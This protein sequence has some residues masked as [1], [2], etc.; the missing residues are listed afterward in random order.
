[1]VPAWAAMIGPVVWLPGSVGNL[2]EWPPSCRTAI[3]ARFARCSLQHLSSYP[4]TWTKDDVRT[5][6]TLARERTKTTAI[7]R[8]LGRSVGATFQTAWAIGVT[9]GEIGREVCERRA[10]M[11]CGGAGCRAQAS[12]PL[13]RSIANWRG[14]TP[15]PG[16][17]PLQVQDCHPRI[18]RREPLSSLL[19]RLVSEPLRL[20]QIAPYQA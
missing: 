4:Q 12:L 1:M 5:L 11:R 3:V 16:R 20:S 15:S 6:K 8:K 14:T 17:N 19:R 18:I 7:T 10:H 9:L 13:N 2:W